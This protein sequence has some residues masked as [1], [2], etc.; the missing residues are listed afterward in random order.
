[1]FYFRIWISKLRICRTELIAATTEDEVR[2][3]VKRD[4]PT[5]SLSSFEKMIF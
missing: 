1:M 4:Y 5:Y 3:I 2:E